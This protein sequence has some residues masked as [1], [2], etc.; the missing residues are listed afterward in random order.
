MTT[1]KEKAEILSHQYQKDFTDEDVTNI[2]S[3]G[4][5]PYP[6]MAD[7]LVTTKGVKALL[8]Q[9]NPKKPLHQT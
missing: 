4:N 2:H 3:M 1:S 7:I 5:N 8:K 6:T 9:L